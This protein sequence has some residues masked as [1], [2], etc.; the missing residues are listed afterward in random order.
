M[1]EEEGYN[2]LLGRPSNSLWLFNVSPL[3]TDPAK[4]ATAQMI[5]LVEVTVLSFAFAWPL[6]LLVY[7]Q[8]TNIIKGSTTKLRF[9]K[10]KYKQLDPSAL[11]QMHSDHFIEALLLEQNED[12]KAFNDYNSVE[13]QPDGA[14]GVFE[15]EVINNSNY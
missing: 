14:I 12:Q 15:T 5:V 9:A 11:A 6:S 2:W 1:A 13:Q 8:V 7:V 4:A 3:I 10:T